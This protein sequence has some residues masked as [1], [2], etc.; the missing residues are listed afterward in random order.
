MKDEEFKYIPLNNEELK[1]LW[2]KHK[3]VIEAFIIENGYDNNNIYIMGGSY[4][5]KKNETKKENAADNDRSC[6]ACQH[7]RYLRCV[8]STQH[9][10]SVF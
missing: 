1:I 2:D 10:R 8:R 3:K 9:Q 7:L 6:C 4:Y 5:V